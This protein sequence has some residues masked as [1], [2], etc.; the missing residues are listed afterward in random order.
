V[1]KPWLGNSALHLAA[2]LIVY[3]VLASMVAVHCAD[4]LSSDGECYLRMAVYYAKGDL[5]HAIFGVWSPLGVW[6][7]VP[8]VWAGM[9]PRHAFRL[10]IGLWGAATVVGTWRLAGRLGLGPALRAG[11]TACA[12]LLAARFSAEHRVDLLVAA[13]LL[14]YLDV[15]MDERL[16]RS[17]RWAFGAGVLGGLAYLA[18]FYGLAF[19]AVHFPLVLVAHAWAQG[20][21]RAPLRAWAVGLG[22]FALAAA[23]WVAA[24]SVRLGRPTLGTVAAE[25]YAVRGPTSGDTRLWAITGLRRPPADAYSVWQ[26]ADQYGVRPTKVP[27]SP[28]ST[29]PNFVQ[30]VR[31]TVR[32]TARIVGHLAA[33]DRFHLGLIA[34]A[35]TPLAMVATW[36]RRE[37]ALRYL[38][39]LLAVA[40]YC[41]GY[42]LVYAGEARYFA[43]IFLLTVAMALHL[44]GLAP[45]V[46]ARLAPRSGQGQRRIV[47]AAIGLF[48]VVSF[49]L[50]S[51]GLLR[52]LLSAAPPGREHRLLAERLAEM[53]VA[54]PLAATNWWDGLHTAYYLDAK[55]AG[56]PAAKDAPGIVAEMRQAGATTLLVW[57]ERRLAAA[58]RL[59]SGLRFVGMIGAGSVTSLARDVWVFRLVGGRET[60]GE[61]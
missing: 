24:V 55:Y 58:L 48:V 36:R 2:M 49:A 52:E 15:V 59:A 29:W 51:A 60:S 8:L 37:V 34:L 16:V 42:A 7:T 50:A 21:R 32:N 14:F 25:V 1:G 23:P 45:R 33:M 17:W 22:G 9:V 53:R 6:L 56:M 13:V 41:G 3:A 61:Q 27:P 12:A 44:A 39:A 47:G 18:K 57:G 5:R 35:L 54:G 10:M 28:L 20:T 4:L 31:G 30:Q 40:V 26:D 46:M 19:F 43:F 11:A 38:V